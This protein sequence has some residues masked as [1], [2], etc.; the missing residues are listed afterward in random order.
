MPM[1]PASSPRNGPAARAPSGPRSQEH[2]IDLCRM[3]GV[4]TPNEAD[5]TG[6][7]YAFEKGA[8]KSAGGDGFADVWKR[9]HFAWEYKGKH[10]DLKAAYQQLLAVPRGPREPAAAGRLRPRPLRDPHQLHEHARQT[11]TGSTSTTSLARP[12]R[13]PAAAPRGHGAPR[14]AAARQDARR[15][16]RGGGAR[17]SPRWPNAC[18]AAAT[19][20]TRSPTSSTGCC[21]A[22]SPRT[23]AC[24]PTGLLARLAATGQDDP[25]A[26]RRRPCASCSRRCP[27]AA[28][29]SAP[30]ASQ[31]FNGGLFDGAD[32]LAAD[33]RARSTLR[34]RS[35]GSTGRRSSRPSSA[36]SSSAASTPSKRTQLGA[37]YTD[38][39][40][41]HAAGRARCCMTPLRRE[42]E[43]TQARGRGAAGRAARRSRRA[44]PRAKNPQ[45]VFNAFLD[46]LRAVR[47][48]DPACGSGNFLYVALQALKDLER[49]AS[50]GRSLTLQDAACSSRGRAQAVLGIEL[51]PYAAELARVV[52]WIGEIQWMLSQRL[53]LRARP[54]PASRSTTSSA[55]TRSST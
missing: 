19:T 2:F 35:R 23:R 45:A 4:Q 10:K 49:E 31:W 39:E 42:F 29:S 25:G 34:R 43:A 5:P 50:S 28:G 12:G 38:R 40:R 26:L 11:S 13:A 37:H 20:R 16:H 8:E 17:S 14:G 24:C 9:G 3:L 22:C 18:A 44:R 21:S 53:R 55:A 7:C 6:D 15:A 52:I 51:N 36:R 33:G 54:D 47:V 32:V 27:T 41:D 46:R 1:T 48:L 30:S